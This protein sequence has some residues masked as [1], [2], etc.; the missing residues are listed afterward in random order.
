MNRILESWNLNLAYPDP[1]KKIHIDSQP[2]FAGVISLSRDFI[3][4][5]NYLRGRMHT[6]T[7]SHQLQ[8]FTARDVP[9]RSQEGML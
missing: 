6:Q 8:G 3:G 9:L 5:Q 1:E 4:V 2:F 7:H